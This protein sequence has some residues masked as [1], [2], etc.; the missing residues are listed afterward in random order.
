MENETNSNKYSKYSSAVEDLA[1]IIACETSGTLEAIPEEVDYI[2]ARKFVEI[3]NADES[4]Q[5]LVLSLVFS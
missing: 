1:N 5:R 4:K 3:I 2:L